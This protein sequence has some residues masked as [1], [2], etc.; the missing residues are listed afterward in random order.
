ME[1]KHSVPTLF[2]HDGGRWEVTT[3][4]SRY[5]IDLDESTITRVPGSSPEHH[6]EDRVPSRA[7]SRKADRHPS[8]SRLRED[9]KQVP[10]LEMS[11]VFIG[12]PL[13]VLLDIVGNGIVTVRRSTPVISILAI[14]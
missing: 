5:I 12:H 14:D 1:N 13:K 7:F 6:K 2:E 9:E 3:E 10:L 4:S 8:R 11:P